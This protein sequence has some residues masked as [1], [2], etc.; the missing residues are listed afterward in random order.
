MV[1]QGIG[2]VGLQWGGN[3]ETSG[4]VSV[5]DIHQLLLF[6]RT[7]KERTT[8]PEAH[9][10]V[11]KPASWFDGWSHLQSNTKVRLCKRM[12]VLILLKFTTGIH[13]CATN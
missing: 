3:G 2:L 4:S 13:L 12:P 11:I 1:D 8:A 10:L 5:Q 7:C 6:N 9:P